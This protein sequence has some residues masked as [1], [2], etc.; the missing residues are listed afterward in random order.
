MEMTGTLGQATI[1]INNDR[2]PVVIKTS[3]VV[4]RRGTKG[5]YRENK[6]KK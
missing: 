5:D 4:G 2:C 6:R 3:Y 1:R